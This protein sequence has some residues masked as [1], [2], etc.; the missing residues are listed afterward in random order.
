MAQYK[1]SKDITLKPAKEIFYIVAAEL[2][3]DDALDERTALIV[4][5]IALLE[6][7]KQSL[8]KD[9]KKRGVVELFVNGSQEMFRD[10]KS[11]DKVLKV[12]EQQRKLLNEL[13]LTPSSSKKIV[14]AVVVDEF[15]EY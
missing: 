8:L 3:K 2:E 1:P 11:V 5:S 10:N 4:E 12:V 15:E 13:Q 14:E 7:M 6:Q 9:I